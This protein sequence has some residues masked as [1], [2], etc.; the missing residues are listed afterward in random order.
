MARWCSPASTSASL[1]NHPAEQ[2]DHL[3]CGDGLLAGNASVPELT[4]RGQRV[5][6]AASISDG[7]VRCLLC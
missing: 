6:L 7:R 2:I 4:D 3:G 5:A 1:Y